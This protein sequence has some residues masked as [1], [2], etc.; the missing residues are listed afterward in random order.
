MSVICR[1]ICSCSVCVYLLGGGPGLS[2]EERVCVCLGDAE[3][4]DGMR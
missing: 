3:N 1:C 4:G 2:V